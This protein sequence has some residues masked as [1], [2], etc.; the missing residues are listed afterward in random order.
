MGILVCPDGAQARSFLWV[1][2]LLAGATVGL[3]LVMGPWGVHRTHPPAHPSAGSLPAGLTLDGISQRCLFF[4][5]IL[6]HAAYPQLCNHFL[7]NGC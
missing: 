2:P 5:I 4:S 3:A 6:H 1:E 7:D